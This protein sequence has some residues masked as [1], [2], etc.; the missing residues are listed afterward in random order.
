MGTYLLLRYIL[1]IAE[2][3]RTFG[4][5]AIS[6]INALKSDKK[7]KIFQEGVSINI[8]WRTIDKWTCLF[9]KVEIMKQ[10]LFKQLEYF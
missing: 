4:F 2:K 9:T 3:C 5:Y 7:M 10:F 6:F 8:R 1:K